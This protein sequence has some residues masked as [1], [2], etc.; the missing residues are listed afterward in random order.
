M[1]SP[2]RDTQRPPRTVDRVDVVAWDQLTFADLSRWEQIRATRPE[3]ASPFFSVRFSRTIDVVRGD[4]SVAVLRDDND[5]VGFLPFHRIGNQAFPVGRCFNDAHNIIC[6]RD[7]QIDWLWI[8][9]QMDVKAF[10]FHAMVGTDPDDLQKYSYVG[11]IRSFCAEL[12]DDSLAFLDKLE[13]EHNTIR[14]QRQKSRKMAREVGPLELEI[15]CRDPDLLQQTIQWK[16]NQ[17]RRTDI[18][19]FFTPDWTRQLLSELH[20][21]PS[22]DTVPGQA[23]GLLS[24]LRAGQN[25][26]AAHYGII[27]GDLL[28]YWFPTYDPAYRRYSPGTALF[29]AI[30]S[31]STRCGIRCID[32]GY[33]EQPYKLKQTDQTSEVAFGCISQSSLYRRWRSVE[34]AAITTIKKAPMKESLKRIWRRMQPQAGI[35]KLR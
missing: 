28:H 20:H 25:I 30:V 12:G 35:S 17:Y 34:T 14:R 7:T 5:I 19:D 9:S 2:I 32:M 21:P 27:E 8:L 18:L 16:R 23:R 33:G 1:S 4:V 22:A 11:T 15:D 6:H 29:T 26:V 10:D 13:R 3:F 31:D 24:V